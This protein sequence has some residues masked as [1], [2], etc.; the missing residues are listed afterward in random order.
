IRHGVVRACEKRPVSAAQVDEIV[1]GIENEVSKK[2]EREVPTR[3]IGEMIMDR[4]K[5]VDKV[6]YVRFAS[7]YREFK[8]PQDF[9]AAVE[10]AGH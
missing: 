8:D 10:G 9:V 4:L 2:Y 7:V 1:Q 5:Q 3:V 6:A